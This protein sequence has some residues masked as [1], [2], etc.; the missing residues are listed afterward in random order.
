MT[1]DIL[2]STGGKDNQQQHPDRD[3]DAGVAKSQIIANDIG[4]ARDEA[5]KLKA[6]AAM[7]FNEDTATATS[8]TTAV[9]QPRLHDSHKIHLPPAPTSIT[10]TYATTL[11]LLLTMHVIFFR[12]WNAGVKRSEVVATY[13][14]VARRKQFH[15]VVGALLSSPAPDYV[16][17]DD[18]SS[19]DRF[20]SPST[21][22]STIGYDTITDRS[23]SLGSD[24]YSNSSVSHAVAPVQ[25]SAALALAPRLWHQFR[26]V[27]WP[28][29]QSKLRPLTI[30]HLAGLPCLFYVSHTMWQC[31]ALEEMAGSSYG[32][33]RVLVGM[34]L[35]SVLLE[36]ASLR[37]LLSLTRES[38]GTAAASTGTSSLH[39]RLL[40][41]GVCTFTSTASAVIVVFGAHFPNVPFDALPFFRG[42]G[43]RMCLALLLLVSARLQPIT[44]VLYG[45]L[46]GML[47]SAGLTSWLGTSYWGNCM[48]VTIGLGCLLSLRAECGARVDGSASRSLQQQSSLDSRAKLLPFIDYV[49]WDGMAVVHSYLHPALH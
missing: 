44:G 21:A 6:V 19:P 12:Q 38:T 5:Q 27:I 34:S 23:I 3:G 45:M 49:S 37:R 29:V 2:K 20:N 11:L 13:R 36:V 31:R 25:Q 48:L 33:F 39:R 14:Q 9:S 47:W 46:S 16:S 40:D 41:R 17:S 42:G 30:G 26:H 15:R 7:F 22:T 24:D 28:I 4:E 35:V 43:Q 10:E 18:I 1:H 32:Y 8:T